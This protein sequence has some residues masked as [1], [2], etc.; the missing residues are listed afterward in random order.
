MVKPIELATQ[1]TGLVLAG[2]KGTRMGGLDK[3]LQPLQGHPLVHWVL[4]AL[5]PQV[6][7]LLINANRSESN[8]RAFGVPVLSDLPLS[9][10]ET[11][12]AYAGPL[13][14]MLAGLR[15][16]TTPWLVTAPC[17]VPVVPPD[18]VQRLL[19]AALT[20]NRLVAM[21]RAVELNPL[22]PSERG[23]LRRQ[24]V[25]CLIHRDLADDLAS[26]LAR[27][28]RKIDRWTDAHQAAMVD[29][30]AENA[31]PFAFANINT[32]QELGALEDL[33]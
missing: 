30:E 3:G 26:F 1:V 27:G 32:L 22:C 33:L 31:P 2:G 12:T 16:C 8:Y 25:F 15:A 9:S 20:Q 7:S 5:K 10:D 14:G 18:Y 29:F 19:Q 11:E 6:H 13:A 24:P 4:Q 21:V 23:A 17:D 28:E